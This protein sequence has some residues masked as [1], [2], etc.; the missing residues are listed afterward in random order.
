MALD[1]LI[2]VSEDEDHCDPD[3]NVGGILIF[4]FDEPMFLDNVVMV[5]NE[6]DTEFDIEYTAGGRNKIFLGDGGDNSVETVTFHDKAGFDDPISALNITMHGSGAISFVAVRPASWSQPALDADTCKSDIAFDASSEF[7]YKDDLFRSTSNPNHAEG[8][9]KTIGGKDL[10]EI[11]L[12]AID[13]TGG[14]KSTCQ[15]GSK[16]PSRSRNPARCKLQ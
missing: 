15:E 4:S 13:R 5:D 14:Q 12:G 1:N 2:I 8:T 11:R 9:T 7:T 10:L 6:E 16:P 3:D